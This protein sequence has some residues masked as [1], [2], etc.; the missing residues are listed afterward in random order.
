MKKVH[1]S[2]MTK[3]RGQLIEFQNPPADAHSV[4]PGN[5]MLAVYPELCA[6]SSYTCSKT[7]VLMAQTRPGFYKWGCPPPTPQDKE[8]Q[9]VC[10]LSVQVLVCLPRGRVTM[11]A[12]CCHYWACQYNCV[13]ISLELWNNHSHPSLCLYLAVTANG[14]IIGYKRAPP[15]VSPNDEMIAWGPRV[16]QCILHYEMKIS[17]IDNF[18]VTLNLVSHNTT[19]SQIMYVWWGIISY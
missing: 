13:V 15:R 3:P 9:G 2:E 5:R 14:V 4:P 17:S 18:I 19:S 6:L 11:V 16:S 1:G 12:S 7:A 10:M 8:L